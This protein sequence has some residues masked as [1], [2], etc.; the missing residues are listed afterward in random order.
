MEGAA[1]RTDGEL[2]QSS[3]MGKEIVKLFGQISFRW[4][5]PRHRR[6]SRILGTRPSG[7]GLKAGFCNGSVL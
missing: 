3:C 6:C 1:D 4:G 5:R 7:L 2:M